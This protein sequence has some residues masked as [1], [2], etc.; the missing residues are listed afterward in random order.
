MII[1]NQR[2]M[3]KK[4]YEHLQY[5]VLFFDSCVRVKSVYLFSRAWLLRN[6]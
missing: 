3:N 4:I 5:L 2:I 1:G 6:K